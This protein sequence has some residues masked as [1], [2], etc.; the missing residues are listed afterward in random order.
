MR[1]HRVAVDALRDPDLG[2]RQA[3]LPTTGRGLIEAAHLRLI[4]LVRRADARHVE[5]L[6]VEVEAELRADPSRLRSGRTRRSSNRTTTARV[7]FPPIGE[8]CTAPPQQADRG[9]VVA[10][11]GT[12]RVAS[13]RAIGPGELAPFPA[14]LLRQQDVARVSDHDHRADA[15]EQLE[16][17]A[18]VVQVA[19]GLVAGDGRAVPGR[20]AGEERGVDRW[21][22][23]RGR[24]RVDDGAGRRPRT[25]RRHGDGDSPRVAS[26]SAA[27]RARPLRRAWD[28]RRGA[29]AARAARRSAAPRT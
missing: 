29:P 3:C 16:D 25:P 14:V 5:H 20:L 7:V 26:R 28:L 17:L 22:G 23:E 27:P 8:A 9:G 4:G 18:E 15:L 2:R 21:R 10:R 19:R 24:Y 1:R 13:G 6:G 11:P 12:Q